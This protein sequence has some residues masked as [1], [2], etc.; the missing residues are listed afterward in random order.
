[1]ENILK[2]V[3]I[4]YFMSRL[5]LKACIYPYCAQWGFSPTFLRKI[6]VKNFYKRRRRIYLRVYKLSGKR[7]NIH[8][9]IK[10]PWY[11]QKK[12]TFWIIYYKKWDLLFQESGLLLPHVGVASITA[13]SEEGAFYLSDIIAPRT[14]TPLL[15][16]RFNFIAI[17]LIWI[18]CKFW[19][20]SIFIVF[21]LFIPAIIFCESLVLFIL[22]VFQFWFR[23][24]VCSLCS[25]FSTRRYFIFLQFRCKF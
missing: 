2:M 7:I 4:R 8:V 1:M 25:S 12:G 24:F 20:F 13:K 23:F 19:H 3:I 5:Y 21:I 16:F 10:L 22:L 6:F 9:I 15:Q 14:L 11:K 18:W 17:P